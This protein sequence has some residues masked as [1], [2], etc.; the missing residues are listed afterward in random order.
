M[1]S[2]L[3]YAGRICGLCGS[4]SLILPSC[5]HTRKPRDK[6][7]GQQLDLRTLRDEMDVTIATHSEGEVQ[8]KVRVKVCASFI[9]W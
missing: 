6:K 4:A 5:L 7:S 3:E 8:A 9:M 2:I 1:V